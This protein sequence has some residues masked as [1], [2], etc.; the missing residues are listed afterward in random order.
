MQAA[1]DEEIFARA[2]EEDR[3]LIS[4]D[5]DF[6]TLLASWGE[7]KPS[8]ILLRRGPWRPERQFTLL[9][10]NLTTI[11]DALDQ[12]SVIVFEPGRIRIRPLPIGGE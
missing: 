6:G 8:I 4:A 9:H 7:K 1:S 10:A 5:T 11:Q 2:A 3:V 12:G